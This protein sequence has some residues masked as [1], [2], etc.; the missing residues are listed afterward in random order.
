MG[1][2][3]KQDKYHPKA[4]FWDQG[5][6]GVNFHIISS[7]K[8]LILSKLGL[9]FTTLTN[10]LTYK[11]S[12]TPGNKRIYDGHFHS[13]LISVV[14]RLQSCLHVLL[15]SPNP[16]LHTSSGYKLM[17]KNSPGHVLV[18][19]GPDPTPSFD[20]TRKVSRITPSCS[21]HIPVPDGWPIFR[22]LDA[23]RWRCEVVRRE[24][25]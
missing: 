11:T 19:D 21:E 17:V 16:P 1:T 7:I 8:R 22:A 10:W 12:K 2:M 15:I 13:I 9:R 20:I 25:F 6:K 5:L 23:L 24:R 18:D 3:T 4:A 14:I